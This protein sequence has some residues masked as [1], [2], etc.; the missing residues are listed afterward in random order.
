MDTAL[1]A[2]A[3]AL[4]DAHRGKAY[5]GCGKCP[6]NAECTS[7]CRPGWDGLREWQEKVNAAAK[8]HTRPNPEQAP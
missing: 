6:I 3:I 8:K 5:S 1:F 7:G 2:E 4:C